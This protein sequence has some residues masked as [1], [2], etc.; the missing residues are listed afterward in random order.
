MAKSGSLN[1][2]MERCS[3]VVEDLH[4]SDLKAPRW[5]GPRNPIRNKWFV[6]ILVSTIRSL[7]PLAATLAPVS[8]IQPSRL[9]HEAS[10]QCSD[11]RSRLLDDKQD[12]RCTA[13]HAKKEQHREDIDVRQQIAEK[14]QLRGYRDSVVIGQ[15]K[16]DDR[17]KRDN[18]PQRQSIQ[19]SSQLHNENVPQPIT[20]SR[21]FIN[22]PLP[23][24][25]LPHRSARHLIVCVYHIICRGPESV[26]LKDLKVIGIRDA[27][28]PDVE[29]QKIMNTR[30]R[31]PRTAPCPRPVR[32]LARRRR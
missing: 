24:K 17:D 9:G 8:K 22:R 19:E 21:G 23:P 15:D 16:N 12:R 1:H 13:Q 11:S 32:T 28:A 2:D 29:C 27:M 5:L 7:R 4:L 6:S 18:L 10:C 26:R 3:R 14:H 25:R 20:K 31:S 30:P